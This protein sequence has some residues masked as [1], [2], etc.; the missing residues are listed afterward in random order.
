MEP[1]LGTVQGSVLSPL[2]G[3]GYLHYVLDLWF[4]TEVKPRLQ[5]KATLIR[6]CDDFI[7]GFEREDEARRVRAVLGKR[8]GRFGLTL[9]PDKTRLLPL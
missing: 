9:H 6:Y 7:M 8:L 4:E 3:T 1:E 5:G 2:L